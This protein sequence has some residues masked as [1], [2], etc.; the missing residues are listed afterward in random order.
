MIVVVC[1]G[2]AKRI[3]EYL[4]VGVTILNFQYSGHVCGPECVEKGLLRLTQNAI[5]DAGPKLKAAYPDG[6]A[7]SKAS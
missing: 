3:E 1:D 2:C 7:G 5:K 4:T 6:G